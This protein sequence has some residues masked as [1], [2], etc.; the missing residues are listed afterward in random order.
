[1]PQDLIVIPESDI[2]L[3]FLRSSGP[4]GQNVNKVET[5]VQLRFDLAATALEQRDAELVL[6]FLDRDRQ[7][8]L[9]HEARLGG[10]AVTPT[11]RLVLERF[12]E[13]DFVV[14]GN[15]DAL[16]SIRL[17]ARHHR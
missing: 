8:R 15:D 2:S 13:V 9:A 16:R 3:S 7:R 10:P 6:E 5:A 14:P 11:A 4:G 12:D 1:M 17:F